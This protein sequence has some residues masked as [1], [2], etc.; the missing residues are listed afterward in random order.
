MGTLAELAQPHAAVVSLMEL[1]KHLK[2]TGGEAVRA[3]EL[4][5]ERTH[6]AL[7]AAHQLVPLRGQSLIG[8]RCFTPG[9][10]RHAHTISDAPAS[11]VYANVACASNACACMLGAC[12]PTPPPS[13]LP[14]RRP[15]PRGR[16][17]PP[18]PSTTPM[19]GAPPPGCSSSF[20][21]A[22]SSSTASTSPW[23]ESHSPRW[24]LTSA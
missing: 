14:T 20:S 12:P 10:C 22:P 24:A 8:G 16:R 19:T 7:V 17:P 3:A 15:S 18:A 23:S 9:A 1:L 4:A 2:L 13:G 21:A 5:V 11:Y 6:Q